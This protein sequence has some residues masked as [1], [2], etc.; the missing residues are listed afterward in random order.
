MKN[1]AIFV[2]AV[3]ALMAVGLMQLPVGEARQLSTRDMDIAMGR[4]LLKDSSENDSSADRKKDSSDSK[5]QDGD[6]KDSGEKDNNSSAESDSS[7]GGDSSQ[8]TQEDRVKTN[9]ALN[10]FFL[11]R[12][13]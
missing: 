5:P 8:M 10:K 3:A 1:T 9:K 4:T 2:L 13:D 6:G 11:S 12:L 7:Q